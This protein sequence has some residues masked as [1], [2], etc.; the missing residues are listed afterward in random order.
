[1]QNVA[2]EQDSVPFA[3]LFDQFADGTDLRGV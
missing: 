2:G 1:M 3:E